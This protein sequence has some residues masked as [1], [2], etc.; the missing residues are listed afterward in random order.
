[1]RYSFLVLVHIIFETK[2]RDFCSRIQC[3]LNLPQIA[4]T[5]LRGSPINQA[6]LFLTRLAGIRVQDFP[7]WEQLRTL[8]KVRDC[9]VHAY[10]HIADSSDELFLRQLAAKSEEVSVDDVGRIAVTKAFCQKHLAAL[11]TL[12]NRLFLCVGWKP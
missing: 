11:Q 2:I 5:D 10:G 12:F 8:Q 7:E 6:K 9:I 4:V 1:M 3:D